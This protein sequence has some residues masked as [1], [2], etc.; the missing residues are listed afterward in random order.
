MALLFLGVTSVGFAGNTWWLLSGNWKWMA[1][2]V[3]A[4]VGLAMVVV[5]PFVWGLIRRT[6]GLPMFGAPTVAELEGERR[7]DL[8]PAGQAGQ[9]GQPDEPGSGGSGAVRH[10]QTQAP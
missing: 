4:L 5:L 9:S 8:A 7:T 3:V 1:A 10:D 6:Q 2:G